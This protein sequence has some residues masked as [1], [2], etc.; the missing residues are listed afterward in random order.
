MSSL[1]YRNV[2]NWFKINPFCDLIQ[3]SDSPFH[4]RIRNTRVGFLFEI[5]SEGSTLIFL[6]NVLIYISP[7]LI[8]SNDP[9]PLLSQ[10]LLF[11]IEKLQV[12]NKEDFHTQPS[13]DLL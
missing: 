7:Q 12:A 1:W 2:Q 6:Y 8:L 13:I 3:R 5:T 10:S 4:L 11:P 9:L